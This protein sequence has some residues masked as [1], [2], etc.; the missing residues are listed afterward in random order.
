MTPNENKI[1]IFNDQQPLFQKIMEVGFS[2]YASSLKNL[3]DFFVLKDRAIRCVDEGTPGGLH[4]AGSGILRDKQEILK[5]FRDA[6]VMG[7]TSHDG[8]GAAKLYARTNGLDESKG[9]ECGKKFAEEIAH[10]LALPY[11]H[12]TAEE[13][14]RPKEFH[15]ARVAY[16][17]GTGTFNF[18]DGKTFPPGFIISRKIQS[19]KDSLFEGSLGLNIAFGKNGFG[20]LLTKT[21]PFILVAIGETEKDVD[22]LK[23][24][25]KKLKHT[26]GNK[27]II[28]SFVFAYSSF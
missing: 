1:I 8:C 23:S 21:D 10:E 13:M 15:I 4:S 18:G 16:Y 2:S 5:I 26:F 27:V 22:N 24:E 6:K 19:E 25:L 20:D 12:I 14:A 3:P 11:Y 7:I 17:D 9:D 28:E